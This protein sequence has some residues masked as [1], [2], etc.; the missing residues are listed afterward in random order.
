MQARQRRLEPRLRV[1]PAAVPRSARGWRRALGLVW[2]GSWCAAHPAAAGTSTLANPT[3]TFAAPGVKDVALTVCDFRG[4]TTSRQSITVLDPHPAISYATITAAFL[5]VGQ[6]GR[7]NGAG[8]GQPPLAVSWQLSSAGTAPSPP[9]TTLASFTPFLDTTGFAPG[10]YNAV[11]AIQNAAGSAQSAPVRFTV[12]A[13]QPEGFYT[14][15][16]CRV[17]DSRQGVAPLASGALQTI[18]VGAAGCG[19]PTTAR[20]VAAS[21]AV[22]GP[23]G[24]GM[25]T[26]FPANYPQPSTSNVNFSPGQTRSGN[27]VLGLATD[28]TLSIAAAPFVGGN[29]TVHLIMDVNGYFK[30]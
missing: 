21:F 3:V 10:V 16:P 27:G 18:N 19:I 30:P 15:T 5:E 24:G 4:C 1:R 20:A 2:L 11:L 6:I 29:G 25:V 14:V 12:L 17:F 13:S 22:V 28:G 9:V 23:T 8:T 7:L 26:F